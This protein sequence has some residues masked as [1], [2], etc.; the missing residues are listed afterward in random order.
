MVSNPVREM[1]ASQSAIAQ[2]YDVSNDFY[3]LW[4]DEHMTYTCAL[5]DD[6][7]EAEALEE[8]QR[9]KVDFYAKLVKAQGAKRVLDIGCGWGGAL[10]RL[11][12]AHGV[13]SGIGLTLSPNQVSWMSEYSHPQVNVRLESWADH[14]PEAPYDAIISIGA[15]EHFARLGLSSQEKVSVYRSFFERCHEWLQLGGCLGLQ[16]IA[17]GNSGVKDFDEFIASEI[18]SESDLPRLAEIAQAIEYLFEIVILQNDRHHYARTLKTWLGRLKANRTEAVQVVEEE[19]VV[20]FERYLRLSSYIFQT[21]NCDLYLI[22]LRRI[23]QP[24]R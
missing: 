6:V 24:R 20:V 16:T 5:W 1:G 10:K 21:G 17:Y 9:S 4:L 18:F 7:N 2:H 15:F 3:R 14:V 13:E 23:D 19:K 22:G 11:V 8:A 12:E